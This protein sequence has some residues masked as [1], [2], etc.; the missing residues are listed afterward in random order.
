MSLEEVK[1]VLRSGKE[2]FKNNKAP[3]PGGASIELVK[4]YPIVGL[5]LITEIF[6]GILKG[7]KM[8]ETWK[9]AFM[10]SIYKKYGKKIVIIIEE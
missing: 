4:H 5:Q 7:G 3:G 6:N 1:K 10:N 8:P 2:S 9:F